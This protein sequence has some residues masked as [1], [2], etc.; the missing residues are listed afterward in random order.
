MY[1][2]HGTSYGNLV[3][4]KHSHGWRTRY[5]HASKLH[6]KDGDYVK[7]G[8]LIGEVGSTGRSTGNH[9]HLEMRHHGK[10]KNPEQ[11]LLCGN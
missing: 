9:L 1:A 5:A 8:Q 3:V 6:V 10:R 7:T 2:E 4:I 11:W